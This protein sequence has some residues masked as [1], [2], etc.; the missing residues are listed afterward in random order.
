MGIMANI[1]CKT[2]GIAG[3]SAVLYDAY[4]V[5]NRRSRCGAAKASVDHF[6]KVVDAKR[7]INDESYVT[8]A[9]QG[10]VADLRM[11]NPVIPVAGKIKGFITG[12]LQ[13]LGNN[14]IPVALSSLALATK[15]FFSKLG[16]WGLAGYGLV[17]ILQEGFGVGKKTP[18][19]N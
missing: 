14:I 17:K 19:D 12:V 9:L 11:N 13:S 3:M 2:V 5:G 16:A 10:K 18:I 8:N 4:K 6:E 15:G 1:V 7:T